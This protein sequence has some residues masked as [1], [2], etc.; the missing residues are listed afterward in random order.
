MQAHLILLHFSDVALFYKLKA[1]TLHQQKA[2]TCFIV[3]LEPTISLRHACKSERS[4]P[5]LFILLFAT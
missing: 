1:R 5:Y 4:F 2:T 3:I